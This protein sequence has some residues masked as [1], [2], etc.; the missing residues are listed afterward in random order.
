MHGQKNGP[1][2]ESR[3]P[4][5]I[6]CCEAASGMDRRGEIASLTGLRGLAALLVVIGHFS[7]WTI[8]APRAEMP[9][10][11]SQWSDAAPGIARYS[12][13]C[14]PAGRLREVTF[15]AS[16]LK[17]ALLSFRAERTFDDRAD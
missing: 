6:M 14:T 2:V 5:R 13:K 17:N 8:V 7:V 3:R 12:H 10:W 1:S 11:I 9:T 4:C 16:E 15:I